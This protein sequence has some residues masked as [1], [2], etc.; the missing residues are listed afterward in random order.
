MKKLALKMLLILILIVADISLIGYFNYI[1]GESWV[2]WVLALGLVP[3]VQ[4]AFYLI[5]GM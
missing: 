5:L 3:G 1:F 2:T 4:A